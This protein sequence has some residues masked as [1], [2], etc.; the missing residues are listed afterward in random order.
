[1]HLDAITANPD[2]E[3]PRRHLGAFVLNLDQMVERLAEDHA[4]ARR[5]AEALAE[6]PG[7]EIDLELTQTN[8]VWFSVE[9]I[10]IAANEFVKH[11]S[12]RGVLSF[13]FPDRRIRLV[14]H[15]DISD[16]D[17]DITIKEIRALCKEG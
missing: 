13:A 12:E 10:N 2:S 17:I 11:L 14:T 8:M 5:L 6:I 7:I 1:M 3:I 16:T 9:Q 15:K 4:R